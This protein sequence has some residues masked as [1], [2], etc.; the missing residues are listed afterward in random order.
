MWVLVQLE[1]GKGPLS[2][3]LLN[4][5]RLCPLY[6]IPAVLLS[7]YLHATTEPI[8]DQR[9][10]FFLLTN[11]AS[12]LAVASV[13]GIS[14]VT[15]ALAAQRRSEANVRKL[16]SHHR[17]AIQSAAARHDV[18]PRLIAAIVYVTHRDQLSP[19]RDAIERLFIRAWGMSLQ[20]RGPGNER[21]E[22]I[23]ADENP[24]LNRALDISI[25]VAQIK[26]R[27]A[28]TASVLATGHTP[29][30]LP[31]PAYYEYRN[32]EPVGGGWPPPITAQ[33]AMN[34]P[35]PVPALDAAR[36]A[37]EQRLRRSRPRGV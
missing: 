13:I 7:D 28:L 19:F 29:D 25:G 17:A 16:V 22:E 37:A 27:T 6:F 8:T 2:T 33:T 34:S 3:F 4:T 20:R 30:T 11:R 35:I 12:R 32:V 9:R 15:F 36:R 1:W 23:G 18:D 26:P 31:R 21:W 14:L 10:G 24:I 5:L